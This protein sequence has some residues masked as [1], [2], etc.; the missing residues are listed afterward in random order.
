[1]FRTF[2]GPAVALA[3]VLLLTQ[4]GANETGA[5]ANSALQTALPPELAEMFPIGREFKGVTI[6]SY[7]GD[8]LK[9]VLTAKLMKRVTQEKLDLFDMVVTVYSG[10][11]E[12]RSETKIHMEEAEYLLMEGRLVS[13]TPAFVEQPQFTMRGEQ[14]IFDTSTQ[15]TRMV[16]GVQVTIPDASAFSPDFGIMSK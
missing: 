2:P 6:P 16:G 11:G 1:M 7:E 4:T 5:L 3:T 13:R 15:K 14:M 10:S 8:V 9:M 12:S